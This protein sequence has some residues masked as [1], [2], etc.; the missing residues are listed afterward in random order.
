MK[1]ALAESFDLATEKEDLQGDLPQVLE[2][3]T[4]AI[5]EARNLGR[6][7]RL[8]GIW[9]RNNL[10]RGVGRALRNSNRFRFHPKECEDDLPGLA[11]LMPTK[12]HSVLD[13][14]ARLPRRLEENGFLCFKILP[15]SFSV[16][17]PFSD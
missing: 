8:Y 12:F 4:S 3:L 11:D 16:S 5:L 1:I 13:L 10:A 17:V 14:V 7:D 9:V 2:E 15:L 6:A